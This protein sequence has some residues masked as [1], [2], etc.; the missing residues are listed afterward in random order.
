LVVTRVFWVQGR[1]QIQIWLLF[2]RHPPLTLLQ[3]VRGE[4]NRCTKA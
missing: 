2:V 4:G 1:L 3:Q